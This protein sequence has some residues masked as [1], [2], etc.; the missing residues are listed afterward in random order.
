MG[1]TASNRIVHKVL[2]RF[3]RARVWRALT[4]PEEF[5]DWFGVTLSNAFAP[6]LVVR[7]TVTS[8]DY[9]GLPFELIVERI[10]PQRLVSW[11]WHPFAVDPGA[12][13]S[14]ERPTI[15]VCTLEDAPGGTLLAVE[16]S[17]FDAIPAGRRAEAYR[18]HDEGW[19]AQLDSLARHMAEAA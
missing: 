8:E 13:Y 9:R 1:P 12:D 6:G 4:L 7:G 5:G 14:G 11:L 2:L 3:P 10:E 19:A 17:G 16:E 18:M 15:V